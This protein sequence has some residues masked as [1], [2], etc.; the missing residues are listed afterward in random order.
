MFSINLDISN[1]SLIALNDV[2][3]MFLIQIV[4]QVLFCIN[5]DTENP[6]KIKKNT[7]IIKSFLKERNYSEEEK[8]KFSETK[9]QEFFRSCNQ[10]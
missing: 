5:N 10:C 9:E 6:A 7:D 2:L 3:R 4:A 8:N 1:D